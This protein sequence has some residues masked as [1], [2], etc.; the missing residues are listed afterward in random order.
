VINDIAIR[1][2]TDHPQTA[3]LVWSRRFKTSL[4]SVY[5]F[6]CLSFCWKCCNLWLLKMVKLNYK[7]VCSF[8]WKCCKINDRQKQQWNLLGQSRWYWWRFIFL[9]P[10]A[11]KSVDSW[12]VFWDFGLTGIQGC[13][14]RE[15]WCVWMFW[16]LQ[17]NGCHNNLIVAWNVLWTIDLDPS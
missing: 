4:P 9:V 10:A 3:P 7:M 1:F 13:T 12:S 8:C 6:I 5:V 11:V 15:D 17:R 16:N 2:Q 14:T